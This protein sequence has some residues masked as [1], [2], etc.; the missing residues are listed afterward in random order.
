MGGFIENEGRVEFC[1][2]D[3]WGT[4]C[5]DAWDVADATVV[6]R[7]LGYTKSSEYYIVLFIMLG[8]SSILVRQLLQLPPYHTTVLM[9]CPSSWTKLVAL[10]M[11]QSWVTV[12]HILLEYMTAY[13]MKML[14]LV[15]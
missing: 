5:D 13:T 7:Q 11:K 6:C 2:N 15:A 3:T 14:E 1:H 12:L 10:V 9:M 4:V 8:L